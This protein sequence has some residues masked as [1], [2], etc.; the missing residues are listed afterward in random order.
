MRKWMLASLIVIVALT[1]CSTSTVEPTA[2]PD[3]AAPATIDVDGIE[4]TYYFTPPAD[5][6]ASLVIMLHGSQQYA[7]AARMR[8]HWEDVAAAEGI[9]V[10]YPEG[11]GLTWN[12]GGCCGPARADQVDDVGFILA[13]VDQLIA[14]YDLDPS[15][16]FVT[17]FSNGGMLAYRL[18][19]ESDRFAAIAPVGATLVIECGE[20]SPVSVLA[21]HGDADRAVPLGGGTTD[22]SGGIRGLPIADVNAFWR[23]V[24][25]CEEPA[26]TTE[27][28]VTT[29]LAVCADEREVGLVMVAGG[30][31]Q[32]P[33]SLVP[34][35]A[36]S[37]AF[38][39]TSMIWEFFD[40]QP[41]D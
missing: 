39:A 21:I 20:P 14:D 3:P 29:S 38:D 35:D 26:V 22:G 25:D 37:T 23:D 17:G 31:H 12:A 27:G 6:G 4:R 5:D 1:G 9:A 40:R 32:W 36:S 16:V 19:C 34:N 24:D 10:A 8:Y 18:A 33:G 15:R 7:A 13:L 41:G 2:P 28:V 11:S 30:G